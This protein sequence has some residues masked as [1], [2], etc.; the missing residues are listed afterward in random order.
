M[1]KI[2]SHQILGQAESLPKCREAILRF[3]DK[4]T[5]VRYD[6]IEVIEE[7][8]FTVSDAEF[9]MTLDRAISRNHQIVKK[10]MKDITETGVTDINDLKSLPQGY[11]SK[12][13]H[14]LAHFLDGFIGIDSA[15]YNLIEDSH[16][17]SEELKKTMTSNPAHY[18]LF[19]LEGYSYSPEEAAL[20][21]M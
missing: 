16:W 4:T 21:H 13:L 19:T 17:V 20:L 9:P 8:I 6:H 2:S 15:F 5:L 10:L 12:A 7:Q 18:F 1:K 14:V 3:F 11:P